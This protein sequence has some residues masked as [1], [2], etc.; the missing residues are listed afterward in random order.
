MVAYFEANKIRMA[1]LTRD[2][3]GAPSVVAKV[4]GDQP[5]PSLSSARPGEW[6]LSWQDTEERHSE[7]YA[8]R[9]VC[10]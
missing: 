5:R 10:K 2:G 6:F 1:T 7:V 9:V 8:A 3:V 4:S